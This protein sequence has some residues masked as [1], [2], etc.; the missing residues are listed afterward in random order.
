M[1]ENQLMA[2]SPSSA[3][4]G[5]AAVAQQLEKISVGGSGKGKGKGKGK[6]NAG[7]GAKGVGAGGAAAAS[8]AVPPSSSGEDVARFPRRPAF[9]TAGSP[10]VVWANFFELS[11]GKLPNLLQY[12]AQVV[13]IG[14]VQRDAGAE[15]KETLKLPY[16]SLLGASGPVDTSTMPEVKGPLLRKVLR[17]V[18]T[19]RL[20]N[21]P[22]ATEMKSKVITLAPLPAWLGSPPMLDDVEVEDS[23]F[24]VQFDGPVV[25]PLDGLQHWLRTMRDERDLNDSF[26]PKFPDVVDAVGILLGHA[27]RMATPGTVSVASRFFSTG[28][29]SER[30]SLGGHNSFLEIV[31]G[32]F[33]SVRPATGR[34]LLNVNVT[35]GVF[36]E[37]GRLSDILRRAGRPTVKLHNMLNRMRVSVDIP[38]VGRKDYTM[39]GLARR[40]DNMRGRERRN[41][42]GSG[43]SGSSV[44]DVVLVRQDFAGPRDVQFRYTSGQ[45]PIPGLK[46]NSMV[47]V[48][49]YFQKSRACPLPFCP[50]RPSADLLSQ[51]TM[52]SCRTCR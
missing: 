34:L 20:I 7:K 16:T 17:H 48:L 4:A 1:L 33:Q 51:N 32:Y 6:G 26:Y 25:L 31:R 18:L 23:V 5:V 9:G 14:R 29:A 42:G 8:A 52:S 47:T 46:D 38:G 37:A 22:A 10:V 11:F 41:S 44:D 45:D 43:N 50:F 21:V 15:G 28:M 13:K 27:P 3:V 40:G 12:N 39:G 24:R 19:E 36:R 35:H 30:S 49:E 2:A